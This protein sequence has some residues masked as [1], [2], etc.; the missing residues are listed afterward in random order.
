MRENMNLGKKTII[1]VLNEGYLT[2]P[3]CLI[4]FELLKS[5]ISKPIFNI[6]KIFQSFVSDS[7]FS[8]FT[9]FSLYSFFFCFSVIIKFFENH[10]FEENMKKRTV[11]DTN[12]C[13]NHLPSAA[14]N[15]WIKHK[16]W[17]VT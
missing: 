13:E 11:N 8:A 6:Y 10:S 7:Y 12:G 17:L 5:N 14:K 4:D 2:K 15:T 9:F 3:P 16:N 1:R